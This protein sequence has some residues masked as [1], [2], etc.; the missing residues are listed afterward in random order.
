MTDEEPI[1]DLVETTIE[2]VRK[3]FLVT[4]K[5]ENKYGDIEV[6]VAESDDFFA[7]ATT[8]KRR[9]SEQ[10][11]NYILVEETNF[12]ELDDFREW[13]KQCIEHNEVKIIIEENDK[14]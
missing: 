4:I 14:N 8:A 2:H 3:G 13:I 5:G 7:S 1:D 9:W 12:W 11:Q 10:N 6:E